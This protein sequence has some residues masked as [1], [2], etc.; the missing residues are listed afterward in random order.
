MRRPSYFH[1]SRTILVSNL[2]LRDADLPFCRNTRYKVSEM[3][4]LRGFG[5]T[6]NLIVSRHDRGRIGFLY[7][8]LERAQ[9]DLTERSFVHLNIVFSARR[10]GVVAHKVLYASL[11]SFTLDAW[12]AAAQFSV[13]YISYHFI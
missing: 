8:H 5:R 11:E 3:V 1:S 12:G 9:I 7:Y 10:L 4:I 2:P 6:Y 13:H